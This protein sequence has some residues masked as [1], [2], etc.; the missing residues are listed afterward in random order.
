MSDDV[1]HPE[2]ERARRQEHATAVQ[3]VG[4]GFMI[5]GGGY[6]LT[7]GPVEQRSKSLAGRQLGAGR[8]RMQERV[9]ACIVLVA[10]GGCWGVCVCVLLVDVQAPRRVTGAF[11]YYM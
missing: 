2:R 4:A 6:D 8:V 3:A 5:V 7:Q 11:G 10:V 1:R 9:L